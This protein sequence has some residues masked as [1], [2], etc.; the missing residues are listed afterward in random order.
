MRSLLSPL[1][2]NVL[3]AALL[4]WCAHVADAASAH[5]RP[6]GGATET[7]RV[8]RRPV[9]CW[10][11]SAARSG[12]CRRDPIHRRAASR[13]SFFVNQ[14][15]VSWDYDHQ[16]CFSCE[17]SCSLYYVLGIPSVFLNL[18]LVLTLLTLIISHSILSISQVKYRVFGSLREKLGG[19]FEIVSLWYN[20]WQTS[21]IKYCQKYS[22]SSV[23]R[24]WRST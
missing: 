10:Q 1:L 11:C 6:V 18:I 20:I 7:A 8:A 23:I 4:Q 21:Q 17:S 2:Q 22:K 12:A 24:E 14:W 9:H 3:S 13:V 5:A 16:F 19:S 15:R